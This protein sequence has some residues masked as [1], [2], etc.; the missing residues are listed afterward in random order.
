MLWTKPQ[1]RKE[2]KT[3]NLRTDEGKDLGHFKSVLNKRNTIILPPGNLID[4]R[5]LRQQL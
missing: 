2:N 4:G 1:D 3:D 5:T